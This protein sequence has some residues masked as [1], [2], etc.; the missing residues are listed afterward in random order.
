[1]I[2]MILKCVSDFIFGKYDISNIQPILI[3]I[4][5]RFDKL[6]L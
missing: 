1:M 4:Y 5:I 6:I 3:I 2:K